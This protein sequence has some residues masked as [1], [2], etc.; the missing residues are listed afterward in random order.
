MNG[1]QK[2]KEQSGRMIEDALFLIMK[3]KPYAEISVSEIT[4]K[5]DLSR[6]TFYRLYKEKDEVLQ[7]YFDRLCQEY[8][9]QAPLLEKYDISQIAGE[10]FNFWYQYRETLLLMHRCGMDE[11]LYL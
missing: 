6:R 10:Y 7:R 4:R 5:A 2:Q 3:E 1:H 11:M 8:C 9:G